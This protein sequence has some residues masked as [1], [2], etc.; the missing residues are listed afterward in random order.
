MIQIILNPIFKHER[1]MIIHK[2]VC[3]CVC[4]CMCVYVCVRVCVCMCVCVIVT[5]WFLLGLYMLGSLPSLDS[6]FHSSGILFILSI[7]RY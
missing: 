7:N 3:V 2:C 6:L 1:M 4:V 5:Y